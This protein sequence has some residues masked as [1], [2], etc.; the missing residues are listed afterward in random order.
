VLVQSYAGSIIHMPENLDPGLKPFLLEF[1]GA[2]VD[3]IY[4]AINHATQAIEKLANIG[5]VR[6]SESKTMSG[7][8]METEFQLLNARLSEKANNLAL[9]EEQIF[10]LWC[11]YMGQ[12]WTG[13]ILYPSNFNLRDAE[14]EITHLKTARETATDPRV[15]QQIDKEIILW[16]GQEPA[17]VFPYEDINPIVGRTYPDGEPIPESLPPAYVPAEQSGYVAQACGNCR[18][19]NGAEGYCTKFD[20]NVRPVYWC[21]K[22]QNGNLK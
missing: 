19:Y 20:A 21:S 8:A 16:L 2:S 4:S 18:F 9:A 22:W 11:Q 15:L 12:E 7:V 6:A 5:A 10:K 17:D 3:S 1:N 13:E 14:M